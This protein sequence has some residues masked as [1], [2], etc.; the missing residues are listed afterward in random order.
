MMQHN[1]SQARGITSAIAAYTVWGIVPVFWKQIT[2]IPPWETLAHRVVWSMLFM[3]GWLAA[4]RQIP[5]LLQ[6]LGQLRAL[7]LLIVSGLVIGINWGIYIYAIGIDRIL[8][9]SLGYFISPLGTILLGVLFFHERLSRAQWL[10]IALAGVG[11]G[12]LAL[13]S[14]QIPY[15]SLILAFS[16]ATYGAIRKRVHVSPLIGTCIETM[17]MAPVAI[18][19]LMWLGGQGALVSL[20]APTTIQWL[21]VCTGVV[22]SMPLLWFSAAARALPMVVLGFLQFLAPTLQFLMAVCVYHE[23]FDATKFFSFLWVWSA[24]AVFIW[25]SWYRSRAMRPA[26]IP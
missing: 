6:A 17:V 20:T 12:L 7:R 11:V 15:I 10:A 13:R 24:I 19:Y 21:L 5:A 1:V 2:D 9:S 8:E 26:T 4:S 22:T 14:H 23:P 18:T 16:F 3:V 25:D